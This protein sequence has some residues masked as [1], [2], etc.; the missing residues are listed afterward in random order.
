MRRAAPGGGAP[1]PPTRG[2]L[3]DPRPQY[4]PRTA[5]GV[6]DITLLLEIRCELRGGLALL[7]RD[8]LLGELVLDVLEGRDLGLLAAGLVL[9]SDQLVILRLELLVGGL[10][11]VALLLDIR[12]QRVLG[13][14]VGAHV[15]LVHA[16]LLEGLDHFVGGSQAVLG[17]DLLEGRVDVLV[18]RRDPGVVRRLLQ[19]LVVDELTGDLLLQLVLVGLLTGGLLLHGGLLELGL[20]GLDELVL[21]D[22]LAVDLRDH[23]GDV[24]DVGL[25]GGLLGAATIARGRLCAAAIAGAGLGGLVVTASGERHDCGERDRHERA[26]D[27]RGAGD[28]HCASWG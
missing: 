11:D 23:V 19:Q 15:L 10:L 12:G 2:A 1:P 28:L 13:G 4:E 6:W 8:G 14:G 26:A 27:L 16:L 7:L 18:A 22:L 3:F 9:L 20:V 24:G 25:G 17:R 21:G 5:Q